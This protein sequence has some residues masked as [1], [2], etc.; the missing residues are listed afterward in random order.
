MYPDPSEPVVPGNRQPSPFT[1]IVCLKGE[2]LPAVQEGE[3][4]YTD[5]FVCQHCQHRD[6]I[7]TVSNI[8]SQ[9]V[10]A[11]LGGSIGFYLFSSKLQE[12]IAGES[13]STGMPTILLLLIA[14]LFTAGFAYVLYQA[15]RGHHLRRAYMNPAKSSQPMVKSGAEAK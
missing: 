15:F 13:A 11:I 6:T 7:P 10:T 12:L 5:N 3:P 9:V 1:C 14:G 2:M 4:D 8:C